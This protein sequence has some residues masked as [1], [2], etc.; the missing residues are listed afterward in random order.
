MLCRND[1]IPDRKSTMLLD[2]NITAQGL[3]E[4]H[5]EDLDVLELPSDNKRLSGW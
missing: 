4:R 2:E 3:K 5:L 1:A